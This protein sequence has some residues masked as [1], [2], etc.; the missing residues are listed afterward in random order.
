M[1]E[2]GRCWTCTSKR[3]CMLRILWHK[4]VNVAIGIGRMGQAL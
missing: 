1:G 2:Q 4:R 3:V